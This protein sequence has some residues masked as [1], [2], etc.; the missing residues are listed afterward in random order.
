MNKDTLKIRMSNLPT[1]VLWVLRLILIRPLRTYFRFVPFSFGK[2]FLWKHV[3]EHLWWLETIVYAKSVFG[4]KLRLDARDIVGRYIYYFGTWEPNLTQWITQGLKPGDTFIDVGSNIGYFTLLASKL[5]GT[6]GNVVAIEALPQTFHVLEQNLRMNSVT[7]VRSAN[8]AAWHR[9]EQLE[10]FTQPESPSGTTTLISEWATQWNLKPVFKVPAK[11]LS[12]I[13]TPDEAKTARMIKVDVEGAEWNV[14]MGLAT[15]LKDSRNDLEII[16]EIA[17][18][19]LESQGKS[20]KELLEFFA[21]FG[22]YPYH[23]ENDYSAVAYFTD[24][25][26]CRPKRL[27]QIPTN[28]DQTDVIFSQKNAESL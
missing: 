14:I 11:P 9:E 1:G 6:Q 22:F 7:N 15:V 17:P 25:F 27:H 2:K 16:M 24:Q 18:A 28:A 20:A 26:P 12:A 3:G 19:L 21:G 5:V 23:L 13:L 10:I 8:V 4:S